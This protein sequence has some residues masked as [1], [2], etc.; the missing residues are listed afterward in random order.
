MKNLLLLFA[1][2][3][4]HLVTGQDFCPDFKLNKKNVKILKFSAEMFTV[5][6]NV[7]FVLAPNVSGGL[8]FNLGKH[9]SIGGAIGG[10]FT[11]S[12]SYFSDTDIFS[13][14]KIETKYYPYCTFE[15]WWYGLKV[16]VF[17]GKDANFIPLPTLHV[18][19]TK[20]KLNNRLIDYTVGFVYFAEAL[21]VNTGISWGFIYSKNKR[22][23]A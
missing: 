12:F 7:D 8:D 20:R 18:G 22:V 9:W 6:G 3:Y 16:S 10:A 11:Q 14:L 17:N 13:M 23:R 4:S 15:K 1:L 5:A 19:Y 2:F 21:T